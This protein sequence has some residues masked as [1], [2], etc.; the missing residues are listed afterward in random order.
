MDGKVNITDV[1]LINA[2]VKKT[3]MLIGDELKNAD[4]NGD[5][6]INITDVALVNAH[7]KK[8]KSLPTSKTGNE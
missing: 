5:E 8:V 6:K 4:V 1:A 7:V 3:K 2:H